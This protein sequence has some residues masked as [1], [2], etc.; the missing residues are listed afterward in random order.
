MGEQDV[1]LTEPGDLGRVVLGGQLVR[2]THRADETAADK[3]QSQALVL[4]DF[5]IDHAMALTQEV[6]PQARDVDIAI[7][8]QGG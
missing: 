5:T 3:A 8:Q 2:G 7:G 6:R 1:D 4:D